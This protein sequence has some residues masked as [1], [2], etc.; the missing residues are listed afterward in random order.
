[1]KVEHDTCPNSAACLSF[2]GIY[3][4]HL[5]KHTGPCLPPCDNLTLSALSV[6]PLVF[7][8]VTKKYKK[9]SP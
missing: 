8:Y 9:W 1:M 7:N 5:L 3:A 2:L 6:G 4:N